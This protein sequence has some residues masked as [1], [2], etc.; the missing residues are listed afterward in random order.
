AESVFEG[1]K[2]PVRSLEISSDG[3]SALAGLAD[4]SIVL[5]DLETREE[6]A[7]LL[8]HTARV[9]D[10][11]FSPDGSLALSG[12]DDGEVIVWDLVTGEEVRRFG[13]HSGLVRAV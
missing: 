4:G 2:G 3:R 11:R 9:N 1:T 5:W 10:V 6:I 12:G 7:R 8:G 13:G